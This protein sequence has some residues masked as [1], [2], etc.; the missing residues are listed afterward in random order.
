M[1]LLF[2][3]VTSAVRLVLKPLLLAKLSCQ[4]GLRSVSIIVESWVELLRLAL[5]LHLVILWRVVMLAIA[6]LFLPVR[7]LAALYRE[8]LLEIQL[9][10]L[11]YALENDLWDRKEQEVQLYVAVKERGMMETMLME[12]EE[13]HDEAISR[14]KLLDSEVQDLKDEIQQLKEVHSRTLWS[15][16]GRGD[17]DVLKAGSKVYRLSQPFVRYTISNESETLTQQRVVAISRSLF[18]GA[19]SLVVGIVVWEAQDPCTPLVVAL[20]GVVTISLMSVVPL[21]NPVEKPTSEAVVLLSF[22]WFLLGT[23][24]CPM[25]PRIGRVLARLG[26]S[27]LG[28]T[29]EWFGL[30]SR[31]YHLA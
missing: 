30:C 17:D 13:E 19:L 24:A 28:Q 5:C 25:L 7:A 20:F 23:L 12:L 6:I 10:R 14:I 4:I 18:S 16:E 11:R 31:V 9:H 27:F 26:W 2:E 15:Y 3:L 29:L 21:L 8:R 22:N 1:A